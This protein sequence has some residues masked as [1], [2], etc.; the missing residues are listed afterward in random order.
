MTLHRY[1]NPL[2]RPKTPVPLAFA[3]ALLACMMENRGLKENLSEP[4]FNKNSLVGGLT[5][6]KNIEVKREY[7][8]QYMEN[9]KLFQTTN[10]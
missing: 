8:S 6:L 9:K 3:P 7:Y 5:P 2:L 4:F 1:T 10:Q